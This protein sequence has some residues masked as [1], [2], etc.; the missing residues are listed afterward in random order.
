MVNQQSVPPEWNEFV[1]EMNDQFMA[2]MEKN[3]EAQASF[4][5]QWSEAVEEGTASQPEIEEGLEGYR[6]AYEAW[7]D[8][9]DTMVDRVDDSMDG[10]EV[11]PSEFRDI[12]LNTA[13]AAFKDVMET[14]TFAAWTGSTV[15]QMLEARQQA[16]QMAEDTLEQ[17]GFATDE[18]VAEVGDRLVELERRQ[19]AVESKLD[20]VLEHL[21]D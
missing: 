2:A 13:N 7:M 20:R 5:E 9:A 8:A 17:L 11:D 12:W 1:T 21:E 3:M 6:D 4:V 16:D 14:T 18:H 10:E 19:H 15:Q